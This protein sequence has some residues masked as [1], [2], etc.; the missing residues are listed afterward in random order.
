MVRKKGEIKKRIKTFAEEK[1]LVWMSFLIVCS[2][3]FNLKFSGEIKLYYSQKVE[4]KVLTA[5]YDEENYVVEGLPKMVDVMLE[6]NE[7]QVKSVATKNEFNAVVDLTKLTLGQHIVPIEIQSVNQ[8]VVAEANPQNVSIIIKQK[9]SQEREAQI[10]FIN[11][12][13]LDSKIELGEPIVSNPSVVITG[14]KDLI[15]KVV[16][17]KAIVDLSNVESLTN[18]E[19]PL[20]AMGADGTKLEVAIEPSFVTV[21]VPYEVPSKTVPFKFSIT[22]LPNDKVV[23]SITASKSEVTVY[24]PEDVLKTITSVEVPIPYEKIKETGSVNVDITPPSIVSEYS[25]VELNIAV[26]VAEKARKT[27]NNVPVAVNNIPSGLKLVNKIT[28]SVTVEGAE[29]EISKIKLSDLKL[30]VNAAQSSQGGT[31][32][33]VLYE[34]LGATV[35]LIIDKVE[36]KL[37]K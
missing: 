20:Y 35:E 17:V 37:T 2:I 22:D 12:E 31:K 9:I 30:S 28:T 29:S 13:K 36:V 10:E 16:S 32:L 4:D 3:L 21:S 19:A 23:E 1:V 8:D 25:V 26:S 33:P 5:V 15:E 24:A 27:F 34:P 6:G 14:A 7:A 11:E 18:Y